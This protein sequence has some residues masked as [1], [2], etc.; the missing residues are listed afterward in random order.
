[1]NKEKYWQQVEKEFSARHI[2]TGERA[3][4]RLWKWA[5]SQWLDSL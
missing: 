4:Y 5:Y 3:V 2:R 1:M